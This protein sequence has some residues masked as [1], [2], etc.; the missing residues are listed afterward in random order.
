MAR[1]YG[2]G[3]K[4]ERVHGAA[5]LSGWRVTTLLGALAL[6]G[7]RAL[8]TVEAATDTEVFHAFVEQVLVP[9]LRPGD[10]V[11]WDNLAPHKHP[12]VEALVVKAGATVLRLPPYSPDFNPIE[13]CWSKVKTHLRG[14]AA[15]SKEALDEAIMA[16]WQAVTPTDAQGWFTLCGY[17]TPS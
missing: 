4:G 8:M 9:A 7:V 10:V 6:D 17:R 12:E 15:R 1:R 3:P 14:A 11:V 16:A 5:P 2:R 13:S